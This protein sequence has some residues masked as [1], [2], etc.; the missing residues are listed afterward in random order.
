[1]FRKWNGGGR[2]IG[3]MCCCCSFCFDLFVVVVGCLF[4]WG[5][6]GGGGWGE[7]RERNV[8]PL[9]PT[10]NVAFKNWWIDVM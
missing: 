3:L 6:G 1:M 4:F 5:G 2:N 9:S 8:C 7:E 10:Q